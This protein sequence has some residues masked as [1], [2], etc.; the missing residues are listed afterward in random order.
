NDRE[1]QAH[2]F[3]PPGASRLADVQRFQQALGQAI[4]RNASIVDRHRRRR[5]RRGRGRKIG[6]R[7]RRVGHSYLFAIGEKTSMNLMAAGPIVTTQIAGK[8]QMTSGNTILAP[9]LAA[10]SSAR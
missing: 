8:M 2:P 6:W 9:S 3:A 4:S 1:R 5:D 7:Y 10:F